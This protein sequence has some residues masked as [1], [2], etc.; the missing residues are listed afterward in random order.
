MRPDVWEGTMTR[1][2]TKR[3][4]GCKSVYREAET[5]PWLK[6]PGQCQETLAFLIGLWFFPE[7]EECRLDERVV[8]ATG[9]RGQGREKGSR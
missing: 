2:V 1:C 9:V 8:L 3:S 7:K 5:Q 6:I 4:H